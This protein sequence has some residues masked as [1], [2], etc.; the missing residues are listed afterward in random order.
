MQSSSNGSY[1]TKNSYLPPKRVSKPNLNVS[2]DKENDMIQSIVSNLDSS[3]KHN[4]K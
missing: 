3:L 1:I 2:T 4:S